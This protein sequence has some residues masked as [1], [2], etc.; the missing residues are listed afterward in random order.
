[1][2][3][4]TAVSFDNVVLMLKK[5]VILSLLNRVTLK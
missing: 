2:V 4:N 3:K 5:F 1:M